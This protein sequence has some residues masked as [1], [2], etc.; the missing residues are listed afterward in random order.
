M[1]LPCMNPFQ[2]K[3]APP[4]KSTTLFA[5]DM[6]ASERA[7]EFGLDYTTAH[8]KLDDNLKLCFDTDTADWTNGNFNHFINLNIVVIIF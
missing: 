7:R 6:D 5:L 3:R 1:P 8:V 4:R 2:P